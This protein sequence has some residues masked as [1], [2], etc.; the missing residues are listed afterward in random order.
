MVVNV[1]AHTYSVYVTPAGGSEVTIGQN[2]AFRTE[3]AGVAS[4]DHWAVASGLTSNTVAVGEYVV[5]AAVT[6]TY[7]QA[8]VAPRPTITVAAGGGSLSL[9]VDTVLGWNYVLE[10]TPSVSPTIVWTPMATNSGT[11]GPLTNLVPISVGTPQQFYRYLV[12]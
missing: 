10:S 5:D 3:Q 1:L 8:P 11:G 4:L 6:A 7:K 2:Y 9:Q 12:R